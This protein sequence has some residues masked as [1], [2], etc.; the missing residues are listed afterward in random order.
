MSYMFNSANQFN[1]DLSNWNQ[2]F[3]Q[4]SYTVKNIDNMFSNCTALFESTYHYKWDFNYINQNPVS[5]SNIIQNI[6]PTNYFQVFVFTIKNDLSTTILSYLG[7]LSSNNQNQDII[8]EF[9]IINQWDVSEVSDMSSL[10][11]Q[12]IAFNQ[13]INQWT[14]NQVTDMS[15]M[16]NQATSFNSTIFTIPDESVISNQSHM[17]DGATLF[18]QD[19]NLWDV[20]N[21]TDMSF[22]F[23][24]TSA[25]NQNVAS[26][27]IADV[28]DM[29]YMFNEANQFNNNLNE[30]NQY[31]NQSSSKVTNM[32]NMFSN[33][34]A[35]FTS[36]LLFKWD[37]NSINQNNVSFT[38]IIQNINQDNTFQVFVF[39]EKTDLSYIIDSYLGGIDSNNQDENIINEF[40]IINNWDVSEVTDMSSLFNQ[41]IAFNQSINQWDV[42]FVTDMSYM[43][44]EANQFNNDLSEW[45]QYFN[46]ASSKITNMDYMFSNC[47]ALFSSDITF[48]WDFNSINQNNVS[49]TNIIQN[50]NQDNTFQVFVF[51]EK[52]DL[53]Y[54]IDSY[55]GGIDS[56]NQDEN[57]INEFNII[58]NWDVSEVTDMSSLFNQYTEFNQDISNWN[59]NQVVDMSYM[60]NQAL[61][62]NQN[63]NQWSLQILSTSIDLNQMFNNATEELDIYFELPSTPIQSLWDTYWLA[64][65]PKV[66]INQNQFSVL[67]EVWF[68]L[69]NVYNNAK[70]LP[71]DPNQNQTYFNQWN[72]NQIPTFNQA[73]QDDTFYMEIMQNNYWFQTNQPT[74][75]AS[76]IKTPPGGTFTDE[77]DQTLDFSSQV[78]QELANKLVAGWYGPIEEWDVSGVTDMSNCFQNCIISSF[79]GVVLG[80]D[81]N[82]I[83]VPSTD[84]NDVFSK[85]DGINSI[86]T[87]TFIPN[88]KVFNND[89]SL[90]DVSLVQNM[91]FMFA[92]AVYWNCGGPS[93]TVWTYD[94]TN[95]VD[96]TDNQYLGYYKGIL[97]PYISGDY[98]SNPFEGQIVNQYQYQ[99]TYCNQPWIDPLSPG[100]YGL[101]YDISFKYKEGS[102]QNK[103]YDY[104]KQGNQY[105]PDNLEPVNASYLIDGGVTDMSSDQ[106]TTWNVNQVTTFAGMFQDAPFYYGSVWDF[107]NSWI[108][109]DIGQTWELD[110]LESGGLD[111]FRSTS[112]NSEST[113]PFTWLMASNIA[114]LI[115]PTQYSALNPGQ[116]GLISL[117]TANLFPWIKYI[118]D[119]DT[120]TDTTDTD[121]TD[122][123]DDSN[124][125]DSDITSINNFIDPGY[126]C[127]GASINYV[128]GSNNYKAPFSVPLASDITVPLQKQSI[129]LRFSEVGVNFMS[130][131][132]VMGSFLF[133]GEFAMSY[134]YAWGYTKSD[135]EYEYYPL[136][137]F[138]SQPTL[139]NIGINSLF[140]T[141]YVN[142]Q[143]ENNNEPVP[144]YFTSLTLPFGLFISNKFHLASATN[145]TYNNQI[146][147][148]GIKLYN[149]QGLYDDY[150]IPTDN[151]SMLT[152]NFGNIKF[153]A[154]RNFA[155]ELQ[156]SFVGGY[157]INV[158]LPVIYEIWQAIDPIMTDISIPYYSFLIQENAN[159][160]ADNVYDLINF[161]NINFGGTGWPP[162]GFNQI[163]NYNPCIMNYTFL[164]WGYSQYWGDIS[165]AS[166]K[167]LDLWTYQYNNP[168][169]EVVCPPWYPRNNG[170]AQ[171]WGVNGNKP[172]QITD[173]PSTVDPDTNQDSS[174]N[175]NTIFSAPSNYYVNTDQ[176]N[177]LNVA[178]V[179]S[180]LGQYISGYTISGAERVQA[181]E[182]IQFY[183]YI[184]NPN[185]S[186]DN[187]LDALPENNL[188]LPVY[189]EYPTALRG[190]PIIAMLALNELISVNLTA[191]MFYYKQGLVIDPNSLSDTVFQSPNTL[192]N[193]LMGT[194]EEFTSFFNY[195][196]NSV[197]SNLLFTRTGIGMQ[198][199]EVVEA[200]I[201]NLNSNEDN[202]TDNN[203][204]NEEEEDYSNTNITFTVNNND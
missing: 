18:N 122:T 149:N 50:I 92:G 34:T 5:Y 175:L 80:S 108:T 62:F 135:N 140:Y 65:A 41:Y 177:Q 124:D 9:N 157:P 154:A 147:I 26:W 36:T 204:D 121:T 155:E 66:K 75:S 69:G 77:S 136:V 191:C 115:Y 134:N 167:E 202:N 130:D 97:K 195:S 88:I 188:T 133:A 139:L 17:F 86:G 45:N 2:Y 183:Q 186:N 67:I 87:Q 22:M 172:N 197:A 56:N 190:W 153:E 51:S 179:T 71:D 27:N 15:Y 165:A 55:L 23:N 196:R 141:N 13:D 81:G 116:S 25:F 14:V 61:V 42:S 168:R 163:Y 96:S 201:N 59:I 8:N 162:D 53:S 118:N 114:K 173:A 90:W 164:Y 150:E 39:S 52:T 35:L 128:P 48:K 171:F 12:Y 85:A 156:L 185:D 101:V 84:I 47:T 181:Y 161:E 30:W 148:Q 146:T 132:V 189:N 3:N 57:I 104:I 131:S 138:P 111:G 112:Y 160:I 180:G 60:F 113:S 182:N 4:L 158:V 127:L 109:T 24:Q 145:A 159:G 100:I 102:I 43:F 129:T 198:N 143:I 120:D 106:L 192:K 199:R 49:F 184:L 78:N 110:S 64:L 166:N 46:Q 70:N 37:F 58:N 137:N 94:E 125:D 28:T 21:V 1:Q 169:N 68:Q 31:F 72:L 7:D 151:S 93:M 44:N 193:F 91:S 54:I 174:L 33:C 38:N 99:T 76:W 10:F 142:N 178:R 187:I 144:M 203:E 19:I 11:N 119:I 79:N 105:N 32:D 107:N 103:Y 63:L 98:L 200:F 20:S 123:D 194:I 73:N 16:F 176:I 170:W 83:V 117:F 82:Q 40:N 6:A 74:T 126:S 95:S 89:L 29:S 152:S